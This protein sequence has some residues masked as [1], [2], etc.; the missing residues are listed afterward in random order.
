MAG[1]V[2]GSKYPLLNDRE[3]LYWKYFVER[4]TVPEIAEIVGCNKNTVEHHIKRHNIPKRKRIR[5]KE[6]NQKISESNIS[7]KKE[8]TKYPELYD[9]EWLIEKYYGENLTAKE[10]GEIVGCCDGNVLR[11]LRNFRIPRKPSK[12]YKPENS[13]MKLLDVRKQSRTHH[14]LW[15]KEWME[16]K[17]INE[18][19]SAADIAAI[20]GC[21][22]SSIHWALHSIGIPVRSVAEAKS[23]PSAIR[24]NLKP[25][26]LENYVND[27]LQSTSP[28]EWR[29]NGDYSCGVSLAGL[30]P[31]F[32]N[33]NGQK[34]VIEVFGDVFHDEKE[35]YR[36]YGESLSWKRTEFG[37]KAIFAQLGYKTIILWESKIKEEGESYI[38]EQI[39][40]VI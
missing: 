6:H 18:Q 26:K 7:T 24:K 17:Y 19:L 3:W 1:V 31:D 27:I 38:L 21:H 4:L 9:K 25:N 8:Q 5:R 36:M 11:A 2:Q 22:R 39:R 28:N 14:Q 15:D 12:L 20:V 23:T 35:I 34:A 29:Y 32:V 33:V 10:V 13:P 16:Q 40:E 30:I 37:R